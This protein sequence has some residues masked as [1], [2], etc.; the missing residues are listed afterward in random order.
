M[1]RRITSQRNPDGTTYIWK[2]DEHE[3]LGVRETP[4]GEKITTTAYCVDNITMEVINYE[5]RNKIN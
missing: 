4:E 3:I 5:N 1:Q 2:F